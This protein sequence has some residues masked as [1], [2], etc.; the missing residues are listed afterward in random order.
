MPTNVSLFYSQ[1]RACVPLISRGAAGCL[2]LW[3]CFSYPCFLEVPGAILLLLLPQ[4]LD[5][6]PLDLTPFPH[7]AEGSVQLS[8][9]AIR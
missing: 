9:P 7:R 6:P 5:P 2:T 8:P 1:P 4:I 3:L